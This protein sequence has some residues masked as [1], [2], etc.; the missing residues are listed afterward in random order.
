MTQSTCFVS[1]IRKYTDVRIH[2]NLVIFHTFDRGGLM[3]PS[4]TSEQQF[5]SEKMKCQIT[6]TLISGFFAGSAFASLGHPSQAMVLGST[7]Y[8]AY[9]ASEECATKPPSDSVTLAAP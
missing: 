7:A 1:H 3:K 9:L 6:Y 5:K 4:Q 2:K 8:L